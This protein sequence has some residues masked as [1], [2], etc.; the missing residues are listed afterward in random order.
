MQ[1]TKP[2]KK[3]HW[4]VIDCRLIS[5]VVFQVMRKSKCMMPVTMVESLWSP[6]YIV[7]QVCRMKAVCILDR[8]LF[9]RQ[10]NC[11]HQSLDHQLVAV[12]ISQFRK[13]YLLLINKLEHQLFGTFFYIIFCCFPTSCATHAVLLRVYLLRSICTTKVSFPLYC[14]VNV[15]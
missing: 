8:S 6:I 12:E 14:N 1:L 2:L 3:I 9:V 15:L 5:F 10:G 4:I 11:R 13:M 7:T